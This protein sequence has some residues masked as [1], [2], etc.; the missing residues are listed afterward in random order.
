M[1]NK[2]HLNTYNIYKISMDNFKMN[3]TSNSIFQTLCKLYKVAE[4]TL[5]EGT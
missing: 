1:T 2:E 5:M 4:H 3:D